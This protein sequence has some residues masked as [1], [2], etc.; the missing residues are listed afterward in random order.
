MTLRGASLAAVLGMLTWRES[1]LPPKPVSSKATVVAP[2][3]LQT[4]SPET[5]NVNE[6]GI[7]RLQFYHSNIFITRCL[8]VSILS[9]S[10]P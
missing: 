5:L 8:Q 1:F 9:G 7:W 6:A 2:G 3:I 4:G 10:N